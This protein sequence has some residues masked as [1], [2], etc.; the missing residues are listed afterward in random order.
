VKWTFVCFL[1]ACG[2]R[3]ADTSNYTYYK[4]VRPIVERSCNSC[5][6]QGGSGPFPLDNYDAL[7]TLR[8]LARD[9]VVNR[10][11]PP[12]FTSKECANYEND[13]SLTDEEIQ[14]FADWVDAGAPEGDPADAPPEDTGSD[15]YERPRL[16]RVD[17]TLAPEAPYVVTAPDE[18]H[19]FNLMWP[20]KET[21]Y[22][23]GLNLRP[24][25]QS[26]LHHIT[27]HLVDPKAA[28]EYIAKEN[29]DPDVGYVCE[30]LTGAVDEGTQEIGGWTGGS[31]ATIYQEG[32]GQRVEPGSIVQLQT[33][34]TITP[35]EVGQVSD[36]TEVQFQIEKEAVE[37]YLTIVLDQKM[38]ELD[39]MIPKDD[40]DVFLEGTVKASREIPTKFWVTGA[41]FHMHYLGIG[42]GVSI[43]HADGTEDCILDLTGWN[44]D[45]QQAYDLMEPILFD[46]SAGDEWRI[47]CHWDNS[48]E[49]QPIIG[50]I[51][52]ESVDIV[53]GTSLDMEM[54]RT[55]VHLTGLAEGEQP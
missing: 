2:N 55:S 22:I 41:G 46:H 9:E 25:D 13:K 19:C 21:M 45:W 14:L 15:G 17:L 54:C 31:L 30:D 16:E 40:P 33:H 11:M 51:Q 23:V 48:Q 8:E 18:V 4:D 35:E 27:I 7:Y 36:L 50:G 1:V 5:H 37:S 39:P 49:N 12:W 44:P 52:R 24:S 26:T 43:K 28:P 6:V 20:L 34:Y 32:T 29:E 38:K 10:Q 3:D 42:G 47:F 53:W